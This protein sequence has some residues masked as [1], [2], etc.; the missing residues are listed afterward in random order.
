MTPIVSS[1]EGTERVRRVPLGRG[2]LGVS[3][4]IHLTALVLVFWVA[5]ALEPPVIPYEVVFVDMVAMAP[6][7]P[8]ELVV[9]TPEDPP[10]TPQEEAPVAEPDPE[11]EP[12]PDTTETPPVLEETPPAEPERPAETETPDE[13]ED[14][15]TVQIEAIR[16]DYPD[17]YQNIIN[18]IRRCFR[19][20]GSGRL[21]V[22]MTFRILRDGSVPDFDVA[23][24]SGDLAFDGA[25]MGAIECAGRAGRLGPLPEDYPF[26]FLPVNYTITSRIGSG[27]PE[28]RPMEGVK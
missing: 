26:D 28:V 13:G 27:E 8:D 15:V 10:P 11:P 24:S 1:G 16:R 6:E 23:R 12:E 22:V 4:G 9:E 7:R 21:E 18:W 14:E 17:Y 20:E 2:A 19:W 5:P 3:L 25:A